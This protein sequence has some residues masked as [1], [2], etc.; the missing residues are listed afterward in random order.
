MMEKTVKI[1]DTEVTITETD[2]GF[3]VTEAP[4]NDLAEYVRENVKMASHET[5]RGVEGSTG[6]NTV[7][8]VDADNT[9][10]SGTTFKEII[11]DDSLRLGR[12][13]IEDDALKVTVGE[14]KF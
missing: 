12:A 7:E 5:A 2:D 9:I 13:T 6:R 1:G 14:S 3:E 4:D 10:I 8:I 11:E